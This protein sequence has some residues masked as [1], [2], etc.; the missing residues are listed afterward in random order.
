MNMVEPIRSVHKINEIKNHLLSAGGKRG[1]RNYFLFVLGINTGPRI[2]DMIK[3]KVSKVVPELRYLTYSEGKTGK[4]KKMMINEQLRDEIS[5]YIKDKDPDDF[6]FPSKKGGHITRIQAYNILSDA[7]RF[8]GLEKIGTHTLRK[9]F[10]YHH[11]KRFKDVALLQM[12]FNHASPS[13]TLRYI[14]IEQ[15]DIDATM[16]DFFI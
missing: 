7:G 12:L 15:D 5:W 9:T 10:G 8:A 16:K 3:F 4:L 13:V 11:Y 6:L 1:D 14:G 2:S